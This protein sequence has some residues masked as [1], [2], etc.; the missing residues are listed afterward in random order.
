MT[1]AELENAKDD[2]A[3]L[4][5]ADAEIREQNSKAAIEAQ[6]QYEN[7]VNA[8]W[9]G[10]KSCIDKR[11]IAGYKIPDVII[12][13]KNGKQVSA[14][15]DD[16]FNYLYNV[17]EDG[18]SQYQIELAN[19]APADRM[20]DELLKAYLKFSGKSYNSLIEMAV[21]QKE[22]KKLRLTANKNKNKI[23]IELK[24]K[25][26]KQKIKAST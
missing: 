14:T 6:K 21:A 19:E 1:I 26:Q 17:N 5:Q 10:V 11:E 20:Q 23:E 22:V 7:E 12:I 15:P 25:I 3:A 18:Y 24:Q 16:F 13:N 9:N 4:Q 8:Y 2:L